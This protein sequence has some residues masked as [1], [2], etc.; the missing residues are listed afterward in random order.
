MRKRI[1][2]LPFILLSIDI[3]WWVLS[4]WGIYSHDYWVVLEFFSHSLSF[5]FFMAFYAYV[6]RYCYYSWACIIGLALLN[7][8]NIFYYFIPIDYF[9][10][11]IGVIL[12]TTFVFAIILKLKNHVKQRQWIYFRIISSAKNRANIGNVFSRYKLRN[13]N[14]ISF[15]YIIRYFFRYYQ[16]NHLVWMDFNK[17][18]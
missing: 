16:I 5:C 6:H 1:K 14:S 18:E 10:L 7:L 9:R 11:Y 2:D 4:F 3:I 8:V 17:S 13:G 12:I 15:F